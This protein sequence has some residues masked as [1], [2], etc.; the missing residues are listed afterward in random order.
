MLMKNFWNCCACNAQ[1]S[2]YD[3]ECQFCECGGDHCKR[4]NCSDPK[5]TAND[6]G[7]PA[8]SHAYE[9]EQD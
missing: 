7:D 6:I 3:G 5:H 4:D 8:A 1:N 2:V 9:S